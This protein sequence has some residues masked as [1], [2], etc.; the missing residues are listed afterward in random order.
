[1]TDDGEV[2]VT[3][4]EDGTEIVAVGSQIAELGFRVKGLRAER[5]KLDE[6]ITDLEAE[7]NPL[8]V[9]HAQLI[10]ELVGTPAQ[11]AAQ[12]AS[13]SAGAL[14]MPVAPATAPVNANLKARVK[15]YLEKAPPGVGAHE[16]AEALTIDSGVVRE[17]MR[18]MVRSARS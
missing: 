3:V 12:A 9:R 13:G 17:V 18:D 6:Q 7:L 11:P 2:E 5:A 4:D 10:A 1:M 8:V 15:A 16:V 14:E